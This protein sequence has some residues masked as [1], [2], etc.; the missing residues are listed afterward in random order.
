[1]PPILINLDW[2]FLVVPLVFAG[3]FVLGIMFRWRKA[4]GEHAFY[5]EEV[6]G[7]RIGGND[8]QLTVAQCQKRADTPTAPIVP[9]VLARAFEL[10]TPTTRPRLTT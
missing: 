1:M 2:Y 10:R 9:P 3:G 6:S 5:G 4:R 7:S 8:H